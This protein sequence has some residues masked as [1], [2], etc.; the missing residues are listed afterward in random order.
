MFRF[1]FVIV[2]AP[3]QKA[4]EAESK[5][6]RHWRS[7]SLTGMELKLHQSINFTWNFRRLLAWAQDTDK[8]STHWLNAFSAGSVNRFTAQ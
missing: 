4:T 7:S 8:A 5:L 2:R 1:R 6:H 3:F